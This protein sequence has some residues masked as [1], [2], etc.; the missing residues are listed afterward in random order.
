MGKDEVAKKCAHEF[1][2]QLKL[3][4]RRKDFHGPLRKGILVAHCSQTWAFARS[5][6]AWA[7]SCLHAMPSGR[8]LN[9]C[10]NTCVATE[11]VSLYLSIKFCCLARGAWRIRRPFY[12]RRGTPGRKDVMMKKALQMFAH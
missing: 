1:P 3:E 8:C 2:T 7:A 4:R 12:H 5:F 11:N 6:K 9:R 10:I